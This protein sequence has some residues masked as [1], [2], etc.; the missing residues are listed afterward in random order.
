MPG[1]I[2]LS[3]HPTMTDKELEY[4]L[5]AIEHVS[6][7][8]RDYQADY[9]YNNHKNEFRHKSEPEDKVGHVVEWFSAG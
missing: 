1:W 7:H 5:D 8:F 9:I 6:N 3:L 2:R 4:V